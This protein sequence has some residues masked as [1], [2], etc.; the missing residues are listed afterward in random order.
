MNLTAFDSF[1]KEARVRQDL[2]MLQ[3]GG[4]YT[5]GVDDRLANFKVTAEAIGLTPLQV[6]AVFAHKH[7]DAIMTYTQGGKV[8]SENIE[9]RFDD[10]INY[11][12]LGMAL[13]EEK[14]EV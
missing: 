1:L 13:I 3:K 2:I 8:A 5:R 10:L 4:D 12:Y 14:Y 7:W 9:G 11:L 6:W